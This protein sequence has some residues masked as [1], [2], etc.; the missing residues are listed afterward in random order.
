MADDR[1]ERATPRRRQKARE[2]GQ[3]ARSRDLS[4]TLAVCGATMLMVWTASAA[5]AAWRQL[6][7]ALLNSASERDWRLGTIALQETEWTAIR[8]FAPAVVGAWA[9]AVTG[10]LAQ[11]GLVLAPA[12]LQPKFER[13]SPAS[14]LSQLCSTQAVSALLK[15]LLPFT[16]MLYCAVKVL[17]RDWDAMASASFVGAGGVLRLIG[18]TTFEIA[19]KSALILLI[20]SGVDYLLVRYRM[21]SGLR[22]T[23]QEIREEQKESEGHPMLK[24]RVRRLQRQMRRRTLL[25]NVQRATVVVTNPTHFAVA[26]EYGPLMAAP[27]VVAKGQN[28]LA[29]QIKETARWHGITI[30]ENPPLAQALYRTVEIDQMIPP[31][32]YEAVA[33]LLAF[34]YR[35]QQRAA[36]G[37]R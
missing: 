1:T 15:S 24:L 8:W 17:A 9:L 29:Q 20:W 7:A 11:G 35:A 13:L 4:S 30:M 26:L 18:D 34:V 31:K 37:G 28:R 33:E 5:L 6:F 12:S 2:Q 27:V 10:S 22:M 16:A 19:W 3:V 32:L 23:R 25:K 21:E 36:R 14:K